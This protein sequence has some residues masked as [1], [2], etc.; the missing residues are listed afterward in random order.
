MIWNWNGLGKD[1]HVA[2]QKL[3]EVGQHGIRV[4]S[5]NWEG[6][7]QV[8]RKEDDLCVDKRKMLLKWSE[9]RN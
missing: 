3:K 9:I 5:G 2:I 6:W 8:L 7:G 1:T 4:V